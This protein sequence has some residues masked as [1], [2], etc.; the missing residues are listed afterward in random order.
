MKIKEKIKS[1]LI[2]N[3][4][5]R[6]FELVSSKYTFIVK[7]PNNENH[8]ISDLFPL[9]IENDWNS[10]F[11]L[12]NIPRLIDPSSE[13]V[14]NNVKFLFFNSDGETI[15]ECEINIKNELKTTINLKELCGKL[16]I[17]S[18]GTFAVFHDKV[19][20]NNLIDGSF[21]AERG[22]V[23][24]ENKKLGPIK[25]YVHGNYDA[26]SSGKNLM[27]LGVT[28][29]FKKKYNIQYVFDDN[30]DYEFFWVNTS[31]KDLV[32]KVI[33]KPGNENS[34]IRVSPGGIKSYICKPIKG[35][36]LR[37]II[38]ESKLNMARPIIFKYMNKSFDVFHG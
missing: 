23:G 7:V 24:Y 1:W 2:K 15:N 21:L 31:D 36:N 38:L 17:S 16:N 26:I 19:F 3:V 35:K 29:F 33:E 30:F 12:L 18:D 6:L 9:R 14:K 8:V 11:E 28:S 34:Y 37:N 25:G 4:D 20:N 13:C 27:L 10:F 22:Y 5:S 32:L